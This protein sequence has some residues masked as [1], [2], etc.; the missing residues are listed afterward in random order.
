M[1]GT[2]PPFLQQNKPRKAAKQTGNADFFCKNI[3]LLGHKPPY[4]RCKT[5]ELCLKE[6]RCFHFSGRKTVKKHGKTAIKPNCAEFAIFRTEGSHGGF[7]CPS[8]AIIS[9]NKN[10]KNKHQKAESGKIAHSCIF[11]SPQHVSAGFYGRSRRFLRH[12]LAPVVRVVP[13]AKPANS[14]A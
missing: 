4:F 11:R 12:H 1:F 2:S 13:E 14:G 8:R 3:G 7:R 6:V 10:K 5:S 9:P